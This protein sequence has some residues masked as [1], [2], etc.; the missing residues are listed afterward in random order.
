MEKELKPCIACGKN[1]PEYKEERCCSG[2]DCACFGL[3][4]EPCLCD[5]CWKRRTP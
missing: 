2:K 4:I 3:P 1:V 5:E